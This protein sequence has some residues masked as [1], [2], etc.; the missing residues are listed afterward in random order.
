M[1]M[2]LVSDGMQDKTP[3]TITFGNIG[4]GTSPQSNA[5]QQVTGTNVPIVIRATL[6]GGTY[7]AGIKSLH[8]FVNSVDVGNVSGLA[9]GSTLDVTLQPGDQFHYQGQKGGTTG[10][11]WNASIA[12]TNLTDGGASVG[13]SFTADVT[14]P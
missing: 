6:S 5:D 14:A 12:L 10:T 1:L 7:D 3:N 13:P 4:P 9:N 2:G 11:N 8:V